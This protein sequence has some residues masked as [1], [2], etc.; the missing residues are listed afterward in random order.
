MNKSMHHILGKP[1][2]EHPL[3]LQADV[4]KTRNN[5]VEEKYD[6]FQSF[7]RGSSSQAMVMNSSE[8]DIFIATS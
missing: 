3:L 8:P 5:V 1:L 2:G 4:K 7:H 6:V